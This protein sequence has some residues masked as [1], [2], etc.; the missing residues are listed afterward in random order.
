MKHF[1][2]LNIL[3]HRKAKQIQLHGVY[4]AMKLFAYS[5]FL[6][7]C[8]HSWA[9][10]R[11]QEER[12][13]LL[14]NLFPSSPLGG[15][16]GRFRG[17]QNDIECVDGLNK[18]LPADCIASAIKKVEPALNKLETENMITNISTQ[19]FNTTGEVDTVV[20]TQVTN[21]M[22]RIE[23]ELSQCPGMVDAMQADTILPFIGGAFEIQV[24]A[25]AQFL[26]GLS[27]S[28]LI[29]GRCQGLG[30]GIEVAATAIFGAFFTEDVTGTWEMIE[31]ADIIPTVVE[32]PYF[33]VREEDSA[34]GI[35]FGVGTALGFDAFSQSTCEFT[36]SAV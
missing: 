17:C 29:Q 31:V 12:I 19:V 11:E 23:A 35:A 4:Q 25:Q 15:R 16:C 1:D 22:K 20:A 3:T 7:T 18:C 9:T 27:P 24:G 32:I 30:F 14:G 10:A 6:L 2:H 8:A 5:F 33:F 28:G 13:D 21:I 36:I 34:I 26:V